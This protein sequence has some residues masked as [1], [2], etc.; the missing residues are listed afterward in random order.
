MG[1]KTRR[2]DIAAARGRASAATI[3]T[4]VRNGRIDRGLSGIDVA[5]AIGVSPAQ[6]SRIERGLVGPLSIE[7]ASMLLAAVGL[8]LVVR[9]RPGGEPLRDAGHV[10]LLDRLRTRLHPSL[11]FQTEVPFPAVS[12][13]RAWD[14]VI[15]GQ[16]WRHG[17]E[18]ETRPTDR[19]ALERRLALKLRD[20]D[21]G[22]LSLLLL[23]SRH[24]REFVRAHGPVLAERFPMASRRALELLA[25]GVDPGRNSIILL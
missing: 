13:F 8:D 1:A 14:A 15:T 20:G 24:N 18:A 22:S 19:Q 9:V 10:A 16:G 2:R 23:N 12:D 6:Y 4:E 7:R 21:V 25:A 17:V 5:R 11:R 3:L